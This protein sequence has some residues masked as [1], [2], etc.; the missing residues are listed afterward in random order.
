VAS[1]RKVR[2]DGSKNKTFINLPSKEGR[3]SVHSPGKNEE[4]KGRQTCGPFAVYLA[5]RKR[6]I[7]LAQKRGERKLGRGLSANGRR[8]KKKVTPWYPRFTG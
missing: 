8:G 1:K 5:K 7:L 6:S 4:R 2:F 3:Q